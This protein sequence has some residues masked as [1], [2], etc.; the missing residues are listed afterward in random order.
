MTNED[1][2]I[3]DELDEPKPLF[4][5]RTY[6]FIKKLVQIVLPAVATL[7][8]TLAAIWGLPWAEE[9]VGT[10]AALTT[11]LG[12]LLGISSKMYEASGNKYV[13]RMVVVEREENGPMFSL[14]LKGDPMELTDRKE[15]TFEVVQARTG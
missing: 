3:L 12:V 5:G 14:E 15:I 7:Y 6:D 11:F 13:G 2:P 10:L 1:L 4:S 8:F 9:V